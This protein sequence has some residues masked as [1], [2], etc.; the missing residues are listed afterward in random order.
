VTVDLEEL[1]ALNEG[2]REFNR[3]A[4][5]LRQKILAFESKDKTALLRYAN[6]AA[7]ETRKLY[8]LLNVRTE[9]KMGEPAVSGVDY[10]TTP[11]QTLLVPADDL[12]KAEGF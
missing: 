8:A 9:T 10:T 6:R 3:Q 5:I 1:Q 2:A 7:D 11:Y 4:M 12:Q